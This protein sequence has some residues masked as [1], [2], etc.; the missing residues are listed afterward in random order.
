VHNGPL[1]R[2]SGGGHLLVISSPRAQRAGFHSLATSFPVRSVACCH[3][4]FPSKWSTLLHSLVVEPASP[5]CASVCA[6]RQDTCPNHGRMR[7][8]TQPN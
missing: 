3:C 2:P 1:V 5:P 4:H 6:T 8:G 7:Q